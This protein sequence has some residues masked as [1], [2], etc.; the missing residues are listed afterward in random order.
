MQLVCEAATR[1]D[2]RAAAGRR[3]GG[4]EGRSMT[5]QNCEPPHSRQRALRFPC[6]HWET[7]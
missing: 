1:E 7:F 2:A 5:S 4:M 6:G 3:D